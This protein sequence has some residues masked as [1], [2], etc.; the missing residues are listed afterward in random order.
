MTGETS[1]N[2]ALLLG[3]FTVLKQRGIMEHSDLKL[4][5][6]VAKAEVAKDQRAAGIISEIEK[7]IRS[8][9]S[10]PT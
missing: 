8:V 10:L 5:F 7:L 9:P 2:R 1:A 3:L 6:E 4:A